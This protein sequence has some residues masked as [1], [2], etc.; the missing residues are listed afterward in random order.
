LDIKQF[1]SDMPGSLT[2]IGRGEHAFTPAP[3]P[4]EW[5]FE[6]R[7]WPL[8]VAAKQQMGILEGTGRTLPNPGILLRPQ[9]NREAI[10]S[11]RLEGTYA[12]PR[13]LLLFEIDA[14]EKSTENRV[15][16]W[17]EVRNCRRAL[18]H[19][20]TSELPLCLR[21]IREMHGILLTAVRGR[22]QA[23]GEFRKIQVGIG[24][25]HRFVPPP[26]ERLHDC[27]ARFETFLNSQ[28]AYDPLIDCFLAHYQFEAIHPFI[29]GNGRVGRMLLVL[30]LQRKCEF[31]KP[32]LYLSEYFERNR[33]EYIQRLFEV[34]TRN[35]W[36]AWIEFCL[37]ATIQQAQETIVRCDQLRRL[38]EDFLQRITATGGHIRLNRIIEELFNNSLIRVTD[39][40]NLLQ[41]SY[42]T[43]LADAERLVAAGILQPVDWVPV[44]SYWAPEIF[45]ITYFGIDN[46]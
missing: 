4:P 32:W 24:V 25:N 22:D 31:T 19:G 23:P 8:L 42:P 5:P 28:S 3:L 21:L 44:K 18:E 12:T 10:Q 33:E 6:E 17:L 13:E 39:I 34:S 16:D 7:L 30:M 11:S 29:D 37:Q 46:D 9:E 40:R 45:Q 14:A 26:P 2:P 41:V 43:A 20:T 15:A 35:A 1:G 27:L 38:R 36:G